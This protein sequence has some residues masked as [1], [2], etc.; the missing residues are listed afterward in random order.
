M[1]VGTMIKCASVVDQNKVILLISIWFLIL[2]FQI[3]ICLQMLLYLITGNSLKYNTC[4][5]A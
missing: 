3:P 2:S 5:H 4:S 1:N